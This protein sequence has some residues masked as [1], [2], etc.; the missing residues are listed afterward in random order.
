MFISVII[1][2]YNSEKTILP[3]VESVLRAI[4][5]IK[6][7]YEIICIDDGSSDNSLQ[8]LTEYAE[9]N[10]GIIVIHQENHGVAHARNVGLNIAKGDYIAFNDSDDIW[11]EDHLESLL[12]VF[13]LCSDCVCVAACHEFVSKK[14]LFLRKVKK[15]KKIYRISLNSQLFKNYF[16][17]QTTLF[18]REIIDSGI[19][20]DYTM[21]YAEEGFFFNLIVSEYPCYFLNKKVSENFFHK[22]KFGESGLSGN[23]RMMEKGELYNLKYAYKNLNVPFFLFIFAY[24]FSLLKYIRRIII[25]DGIKLTLKLK[26]K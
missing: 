20:F 18:T 12:S 6:C 1:P 3:C 10:E 17:P 25:T 26:T 24:T 14:K 7:D 21:R 5:K 11:T 22:D 19:R 9:K 8:L 16:S 13:E 4:N 2:V 23:L 15:Y